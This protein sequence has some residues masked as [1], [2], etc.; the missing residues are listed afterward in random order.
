ML[1][2]S[3][4]YP[5]FNFKSMQL[6]LEMECHQIS[7]SGTEH[8]EPGILRASQ[9]NGQNYTNNISKRIFVNK[10]VVLHIVEIL[11]HRWQ[12]PMTL[13]IIA[14][15]GLATQGVRASAAII[16]TLNVRGPSYLDLTRS[17]SWLLMSWLLTSGSW[18]PGSLRCQDISSH[19]IDSIE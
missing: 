16:L 9:Q 13:H 3:Y 10:N 14:T 6:L 7:S 5:I 18:C 1:G 17:L 15:D 12:G 2:I 8:I 4:W 19:N 11:H